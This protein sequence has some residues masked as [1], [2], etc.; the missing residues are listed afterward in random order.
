MG[1]NWDQGSRQKSTPQSG[2]HHEPGMLCR[3]PQGLYVEDSN[4]SLQQPILARGDPQIC[5]FSHYSGWI[6]PERA[7]PRWP[8]TGGP[9]GVGLSKCGGARTAHMTGIPA[10]T[11]SLTLGS[12]VFMHSPLEQSSRVHRLRLL[13]ASWTWKESIAGRSLDLGRS[14]VQGSGLSVGAGLVQ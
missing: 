9:P 10:L 8:P 3:F 7:Q 5:P 1:K 4:G 14:T 6:G 13:G 12:F 2:A 11:N